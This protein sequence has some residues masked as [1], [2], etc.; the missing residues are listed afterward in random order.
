MEMV[1][2]LEQ[3]PE[4]DNIAAELD[5]VKE[6]ALDA[7]QT[8]IGCRKY[9]VTNVPKKTLECDL[10][11]PS[12]VVSSGLL[13]RKFKQR[14]L[15]ID[16][17]DWDKPMPGGMTEWGH[18]DNVAGRFGNHDDHIGSNL[19]MNLIDS[20]CIKYDMEYIFHHFVVYHIPHLAT[21]RR[22]I[23]RGS[24]RVTPPMV[25]ES[26]P[27]CSLNSVLTLCVGGGCSY[28]GAG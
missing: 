19:L 23:S 27:E 25:S 16:R 24:V 12:R 15:T 18:T 9:F 13:C 1:N 2:I 4:D 8:K 17:R 11:T 28:Y 22:C 5:A 21:C 7:R 14:C 10:P 6:P 26:G 3:Y 20:V